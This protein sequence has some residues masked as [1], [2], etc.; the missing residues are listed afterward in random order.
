MYLELIQELKSHLI[1]EDETKLDDTAVSDSGINP[2]SDISKTDSAI[3]DANELAAID[4]EAAKIYDT[5][6]YTNNK[7]NTM[8]ILNDFHTIVY[9]DRHD[10]NKVI[11]MQGSKLL[12]NYIIKNN[13]KI[14][15]SSNPWVLINKNMPNY[16]EDLAIAKLNAEQSHLGTGI[17]SV[18]FLPSDPKIIMNK[19]KILL[20]E[21][22]AG[23]NNVF[24]EISAI[25]DELR[26][27]GV[28]SLK[29]FKNLYENLH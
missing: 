3:M 20:A 16:F 4:I 23:N 2:P 9:K 25:A 19:L 6:K 13:P 18:K 8:Q 21:K 7:N 12:I 27:T 5:I 24:D 15:K 10:K 1:D 26:R 14:N 11:S 17:K 29:Q 28:L 22:S